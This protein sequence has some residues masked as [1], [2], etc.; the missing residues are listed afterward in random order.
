MCLKISPQLS[1]PYPDVTPIPVPLKIIQAPF[2]E[3]GRL[4]KLVLPCLET[5]SRVQ[6]ASPL[7]WANLGVGPVAADIT[8][9][10]IRLWMRQQLLL[11]T[12]SLP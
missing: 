6:V 5:S 12:S 9:T 3:G 8:H 2:G 11:D 7:G 10:H 4:S 1:P